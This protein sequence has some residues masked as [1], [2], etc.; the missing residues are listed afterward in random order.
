VGDTFNF[1]LS[2]LYS[3]APCRFSETQATVCLPYHKLERLTHHQKRCPESCCHCLSEHV[4]SKFFLTWPTVQFQWLHYL[5]FVHIQFQITE[6]FF[7]C[8]SVNLRSSANMMYGFPWAA[9]KCLTKSINY[10]SVYGRP[11]CIFLMQD[12]ACL[13][14]FQPELNWLSSRCLSFMSLYSDHKYE[15]QVPQYIQSYLLW[16]HH[17]AFPSYI[18]LAASLQVHLATVWAVLSNTV[19]CFIISLAFCVSC[20]FIMWWV[21]YG[22]SL[23]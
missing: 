1:G 18:C 4:Q 21:N 20:S 3:Q 9:L 17:F 2:H 6:N 14:M 5:D 11:T 22:H 7:H 23:V 10:V 13:V 19:D 15:L 8:C 16:Q 12:I